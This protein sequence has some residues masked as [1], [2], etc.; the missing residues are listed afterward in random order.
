MHQRSP[1]VRQLRV[2]VANELRVSYIEPTSNTQQCS[3]MFGTEVSRVLVGRL[4]ALAIP[5][6]GS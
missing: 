2:F 4:T 3:E 5:S 6:G 1:R